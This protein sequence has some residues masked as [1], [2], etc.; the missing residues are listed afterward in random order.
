MSPDG[1][2]LAT[3]QKGAVQLWQINPGDEKPLQE[4][5]LLPARMGEKIASLSW[6]PDGRT[7]ASSS[8]DGRVRL[9]DAAAGSEQ[10]VLEHASYITD[11]A[12]S[13]DGVILAAGTGADEILLWNAQSGENLLAFTGLSDSAT[14]FDWSSDGAYLAAASLYAGEARVWR[15]T[16]LETGAET[17]A[18]GGT[19][20]PPAAD[21]NNFTSQ[22][23][24][25]AFSYPPDW[26]TNDISG[27]TTAI[28]IAPDEDGASMFRGITPPGDNA[29]VLVGILPANQAATQEL[30]E[31]HAGL[32]DGFSDLLSLRPLNEPTAYPGDGVN[33]IR[34][35]LVGALADGSQV[36]Y[37]FTIYGNDETAGYQGNRIFH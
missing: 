34:Q 25:L 22:D 30:P 27:E 10:L 17:P 36:H 24:V 8:N 28:M 29:F 15:V 9:W 2:R 6:S 14:D 32:V 7:L 26:E 18:D 21:T 35:D 20:V 33:R 16:P 5:L 11:I 4:L 1:T 23:G 37:I 3:S 13:P 12:W 31:L 19:A